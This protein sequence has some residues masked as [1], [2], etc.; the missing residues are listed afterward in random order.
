[1]GCVL[2]NK[3]LVLDCFYK[4][5]LFGSYPFLSINQLHC[6]SVQSYLT[7]IDMPATEGASR[8]VEYGDEAALADAVIVGAY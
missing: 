5:L 1:M 8:P 4:N 7:Y 2:C 3:S 6:I